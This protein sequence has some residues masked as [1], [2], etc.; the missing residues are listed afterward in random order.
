MKRIFLILAIVLAVAGT[1]F[2]FF[3]RESADLSVKSVMG[4]NP[5]I[6][7]PKKRL[8]PT[9]GIAPAEPWRKGEA[10]APARGLSVSRFAEGL[11][12]PRWLYRLP[13]GDM[14]VAE[15]NKPDAARKP[16]GLMDRIAGWL[17]NRAGAGVPSA[18]RITLLRDAD[19]DG[20]AEVRTRFL[21][22]LKSPFGMALIGDALYVANNDAVLRF[23]YRPGETK[24]TAKG[25][26][27]MRLPGDT[28]GMGHWTRNI[29]ASADGTKLYVAVGSSTNIADNGM[30]AEE[31]RAA[32]HE[33]DL[34]SGR[35]RIWASGLRNP[36]G[37]DW[38]PVTGELWTVVNERDMLGSDVPPDYLTSVEFG[39]FYGWPWYYWRGYVDKRVPQPETD[40]REYMTRPVY[41]LGPHTASLGLAFSDG[42]T[43]GPRFVEGAFIGQHGSWNRSPPSGYKVVFVPFKQG[44]PA[45]LPVDVLSGFLSTDGKARGRPVGI[46]PDGKGALLVADDVGN[47]IWRV[48][49]R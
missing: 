4:T 49:G 2:W 14:L 15:S 45:G 37:M 20:M 31:G 10:P 25:E 29:V 9:V 23:P 8:L 12:H 21:G 33:L 39:G 34:P 5:V 7:E 38:N 13:N 3:A 44:K 48:A 26:S 47:V 17:M 11:D 16:D 6:A 40:M 35:S 18:D 22:G 46:A 19:G 42:R 32:I 30:A 27:V 41:A 1:M 43:L 36:V 28:G 24:I